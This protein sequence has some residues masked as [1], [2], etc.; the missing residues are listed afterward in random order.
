[1]LLINLNNRSEKGESEIQ[2][3][4]TLKYVVRKKWPHSFYPFEFEQNVRNTAQL[5][6]QN[7]QPGDKTKKDFHF[8]LF[9]LKNRK[10]EKNFK[11]IS[12][13]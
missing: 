2:G 9:I 11:T 5:Y 4:T 10:H 1:M 8:V 13:Y 7:I 6:I 12:R 3:Q